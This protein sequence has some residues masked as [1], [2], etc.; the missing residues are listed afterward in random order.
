[1]QTFYRTSCTLFAA[2]ACALTSP[3]T[4][5]EY[6]SPSFDSGFSPESS[7]CGELLS[8]EN[9]A[10]NVVLNGYE[11]DRYRFF[12]TTDAPPGMFSKTP[13]ISWPSLTLRYMVANTAADNSVARV[14][15]RLARLDD[16]YPVA[17]STP[18]SWT[19]TNDSCNPLDPPGE[20]GF[21]R[22]NYSATEASGK[23]TISV[24]RAEPTDQA[25]SVQYSTRNGTATAGSDYIANSGTLTF[26]AHENKKSFDITVQNNTDIGDETFSISLFNPDIKVPIVRGDTTVTIVDSTNAGEFSM[27]SSTFTIHESDRH[28]AIPVNRTGS[29]DGIATVD[30]IVKNGTA[31][32]STD[33]ILQTPSSGILLWAEGERRKDITVQIIDDDTIEA[34]ERFSVQLSSVSMGATLGNSRTATIEIIDSSDAGRIEFAQ[35]RYN[36]E[37]SATLTAEVQRT[38]TGTANVSGP[39]SVTYAVK[40]GS[41]TAGDD[42]SHV[43]GTLT[44]PHGDTGTRMIT[45]PINA[46]STIEGTEKFQLVL[47]TPVPSRLLLGAPVDVTINDTTQV[48]PVQLVVADGTPLSYDEDSAGSIAIPV[49][50]MGDSS[51]RVSLPYSI[52]APGDSASQTDYQADS[53]NLTWGPNDTSPKYINITIVNDNITERE[54]TL[55]ILFGSATSTWPEGLLDAPL[56]PTVSVPANLT[57]RIPEN[58]TFSDPTEQPV[59]ALQTVTP[60]SV[61]AVNLPV[62]IGPMSVRVVEVSTPDSCGALDAAG[63]ALPDCDF[64]PV[65]GVGVTWTVIPDPTAITTEVATIL[66]EGQARGSTALTTADEAGSTEISVRVLRRGLIG[67]RAAPD[68]GLTPTVLSDAGSILFSIR[69]GLGGASGLTSNEQN[70]ARVIDLACD[71]IDSNAVTIPATTATQDFISLCDLEDEEPAEIK[72][73]YNRLLPEEIFTL[74]DAAIDMADIQ[75]TNVQSRINSIRSGRTGA[76]DFSGLSLTIADQHLAGYILDSITGQL[77]TGGSAG[78]GFTSPWGFF[79]NG[80]VSFGDANDSV[81]EIGQDFNT[82]GLTIGADYRLSADTVVGGSLGITRHDGDFDNRGGS[83]K[84]DGTY[85]TVF[86]TWFNSG[87]AYVDGV[88]E[89]GRNQYDIERRIDLGITP[90]ANSRLQV[91]LAE[92][93]A[94]G[95]TDSDTYSLTLGAGWT[96]AKGALQ[97]GPYGRLSF[98]SASID[99]FNESVSDTSLPGTGHV[100][101]IAAHRTRSTT[102]AFGGQISR[103]FSTKRGVF[104]PQFRLEA[105]LESQ[106]SPDGVTATFSFDPLQT[107][108]SIE[109]DKK[110]TSVLNYGLGGSA[111]FPNGRSAFLFYEGTAANDR[112]NQHWLKGGVR[113]EF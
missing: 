111:V 109:G 59:Y 36:T 65:A 108:F 37:E 112:V 2:L 47:S 67:V 13:D 57:L 102:L 99:N 24:L 74:G 27:Q 86:G 81:N 98:S 3:V 87:G 83:S 80:S 30:F 100:L 66:V 61:A 77:L 33:Y 72:Q 16:G 104:V 21:T 79:A 48:S 1:M 75:V 50:R 84:L 64:A 9:W 15:A 68:N 52:H 42:F 71:A 14:S 40:S 8:Y 62:E 92:Q 53:G 58:D 69:A 46:D 70:L 32:E 20:I 89:V 25:I 39:A 43:S 101:T 44:W 26:A 97:F 95:N 73:A 4:A 29:T 78:D 23:A 55:S 91:S 12:V 76:L 34:P 82:R 60:E 17:Y 18:R 106:Q 90:V 94:R 7:T 38:A 22:E 49:L 85:A 110:D 6:S 11:D 105:Q 103:T 10:Q 5:I 19:I 63:L 51:S 88:L 41:A 113:L 93:Y 96:F 56:T 31:L 54:E 28:V 35:N 45:V 107:A